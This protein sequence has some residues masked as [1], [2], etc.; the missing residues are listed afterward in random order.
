MNE[1]IK[2]QAVIVGNLPYNVSVKI[3]EYC[4][5]NIPRIKHAVFMFQKEVAMR[6][7]ACPGT[8]DYSSLSVYAAYHYNIE[9]IRDISG[10]NFWP[11]AGV[12]S[13]VLKFTPK[14]KRLFEAQEE[15]SFLAF[16][17]QAFTQKRK[18]LKNNLK[19]YSNLDMILTDLGFSASV[20]AEEL[21]LDDFANLYK[22]LKAI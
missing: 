20:R 12:M 21:Y 14:D 2:N 11:N 8:K 9:K 18:T 17:K 7:S 3:F 10:G 15:K 1:L 13:T 5:R 19:N 16:C 4:T 22:K 6:I